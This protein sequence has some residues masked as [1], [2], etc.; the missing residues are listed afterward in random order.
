MQ[1]VDA[2]DA[3]VAVSASQVVVVSVRNTTHHHQIRHKPFQVTESPGKCG[4]KHMQGILLPDF[5][6]N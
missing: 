3:Y 4:N 5:M 1:A 2:H 6:L